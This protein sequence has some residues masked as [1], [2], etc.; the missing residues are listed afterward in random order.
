MKTKLET[1]NSTR[2]L[3]NAKTYTIY[4]P[5]LALECKRLPA[6]SANREVGE[7]RKL[8]Y[9]EEKHAHLRTIR[10]VRFYLENV[11]LLIKPD[12]LR[13]WIRSTA[14]RDADDT[15]LDLRNQGY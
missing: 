12:R 4:D 3:I 1:L 11:L 8:I 10:V 14:I 13:Y 15:L 6:P 5:I 2:F 7:L 9:D